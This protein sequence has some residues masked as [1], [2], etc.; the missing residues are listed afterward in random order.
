MSVNLTRPEPEER[1]CLHCAF[2]DLIDQFYAELN[3][4]GSEPAIDAGEVL[5]AIAKTVA[6]ITSGQDGAEC[7]K[8]IEQ[9]MRQ[10]V[11]YDADFRRENEAGSPSRH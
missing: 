6:E 5:E 2:L 3:S 4:E 9:L 10:I 1:A 7:Q 11:E 8:T